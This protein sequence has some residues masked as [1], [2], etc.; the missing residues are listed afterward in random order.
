MLRCRHD[1]ATIESRDASA[2]PLYAY[3]VNADD[4][5]GYSDAQQGVLERK[6]CVIRQFVVGVCFHGTAVI[7]YNAATPRHVRRCLQH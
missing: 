7:K 4:G 6:D 1:I 3:V 2:S 5:G